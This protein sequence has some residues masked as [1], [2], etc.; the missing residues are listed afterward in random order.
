MEAWICMY[1]E[2]NRSKMIYS[3]FIE[4][5]AYEALR[6]V[7]TILDRIQ[8][9]PY[10]DTEKCFDIKVI[11][12]ELLQNAI[13]HGNECDYS[14]KIH[15]DVFLQESRRMLDITVKDQGNGFNPLKTMDIK[16]PR[17]EVC[18]PMAMDES[19]RGLFI[20]QNLCDGIEFNNV[21]NAITVHKQL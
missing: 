11:L 8:T 3:E 10:V 18:D 6:E 1:E 13:K 20:V 9:V 4:S 16:F 17:V 2:N 15:V 5:D 7:G 14:K 12:S 21:G 19:G